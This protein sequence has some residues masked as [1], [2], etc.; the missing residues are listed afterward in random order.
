MPKDISAC[1]VFGTVGAT[2]VVTTEST[3]VYNVSLVASGAATIAVQNETT[4]KFT[5]YG[6]AGSMLSI[7]PVK[8]MLFNLGLKVVNA[9]TGSWMVAYAPAKKS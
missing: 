2:V 3:L 7:N 5:W 4:S 1:I 6:T 8:P 9:G